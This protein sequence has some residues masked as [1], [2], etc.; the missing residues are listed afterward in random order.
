M[1]A[2]LKCLVDRFRSFVW[3]LLLCMCQVYVKLVESV[4][5]FV[6]FRF[7]SRKKERKKELIGEEG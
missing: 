6:S 2:Q 4:N 3:C 5:R 1:N 7:V